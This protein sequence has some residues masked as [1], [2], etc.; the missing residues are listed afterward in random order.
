[1]ASIARLARASSLPLNPDSAESGLAMP[2]A[3]L[4]EMARRRAMAVD[5]ASLLEVCPD[6]ILSSCSYLDYRKS[7]TLHAPL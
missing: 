4:D 2:L 5:L 6:I 1:L 7:G 3:P